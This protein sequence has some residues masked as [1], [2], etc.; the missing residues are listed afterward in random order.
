MCTC[1]LLKTGAVR[2]VS[3]WDMFLRLYQRLIET[4]SWIECI[5][6]SKSAVSLCAAVFPALQLVHSLLSF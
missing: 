3:F 6:V 4:L 2:S 1:T 5:V